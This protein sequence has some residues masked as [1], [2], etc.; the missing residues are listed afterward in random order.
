M[1]KRTIKQKVTEVCVMIQ[2]IKQIKT[3]YIYACVHAYTHTHMYIWIPV[4]ASSSMI[5]WNQFLFY[6]YQI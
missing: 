1:S 3:K 2:G 4:L 5:V 6:D